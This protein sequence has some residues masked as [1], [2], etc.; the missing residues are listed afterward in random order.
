MTSSHE[1][2]HVRQHFKECFGT[3]SMRVFEND[4]LVQFNVGEHVFPFAFHLPNR[5]SLPSTTLTDFGG[6][7]LLEPTYFGSVS[8]ELSAFF[9]GKNNGTMCAPGKISRSTN[10]C[11]HGSSHSFISEGDDSMWRAGGRVSDKVDHSSSNRAGTWTAAQIDC[12]CSNGCR[13]GI[14]VVHLF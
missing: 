13:D 1:S 6:L 9:D 10:C 2:G 8:Y 14:H 7:L 12:F 4:N 3:L 11:A 5:I